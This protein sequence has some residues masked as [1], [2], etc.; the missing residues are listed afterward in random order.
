MNNCTKTLSFKIQFTNTQLE[1]VNRYLEISRHIWNHGLACLIELE[2]FSRAYRDEADLDDKGKPRWKAAPCCPLPWGYRRIDP[3]GEWV[4]GNIA[5]YSPIQDSRRPY[6][7]CCPL[8]Q[9]YRDPKLGLSL[10]GKYTLQYYF[11]QKNHPNWSDLKEIG[12]WYARG[13]C[14]SLYKAWSEYKSGKRGK[15]R[16]KSIRDGYKSLSH[17]DGAKVIVDPIAGKTKDEQPRDAEILLPK[18]GRVKVPY[19]WQDMGA[20][21]IAVLKIVQ[22]PDGWYLQITCSKFPAIEPKPVTATVGLCPVGR[23]GVLA[24]DDRGREYTLTLDDPQLVKR[25]EELQKQSA[26][27]RAA[28]H[29]MQQSGQT[30]KGN[31]LAKTERKIARI[32]ALLADRRKSQRE[33]IAS[34]LAQQAAAVAIVKPNSAQ[35]PHPKPEIRPGT[36]PVHYDPNGAEVVAELNKEKSQHGLGEFVALIKQK[37][38]EY[39]RTLS[40]S[41]KI[42][43][44]QLK[45]ATYLSIAKAIKPML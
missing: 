22:K 20:L 14:D 24:V 29:R 15:P 26:R 19:Y 6:R 43:K 16:F 11:V 37:S 34:F 9:D 1:S 13:I 40:E 30:V 7:Q 23:S 32:S 33:K 21:P 44:K 5:P 28:V 4:E 17:G 35:I 3:K 18:V 38:A 41:P 2:Q 8:P 45:K 31:N 25:K 42:D 36:F 39:E 10:V 12:S 27:K